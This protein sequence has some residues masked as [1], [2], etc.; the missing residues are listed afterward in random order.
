MI[1][2]RNLERVC[3]VSDTHLGFDRAKEA[4]FSKFLDQDMVKEA[5]ELILLGDIVDH[6]VADDRVLFRSF[7][8]SIRKID[9]LDCTKVYVIGNHDYVWHRYIG[10]YLPD[11]EVVEHYTC[12]VGDKMYL[13]VHGHQY[14]RLCKGFSMIDVAN[15]LS[16]I[17]D[18]Q[19][20]ITKKAVK[21]AFTRWIWDKWL[22][23]LTDRPKYLT[24]EEIIE[25]GY[26]N[27]LKLE[28]DET[29]DVL[30]S[31]H[32]HIP[33]LVD[34]EKG[35]RKF[36]WGNTGSWVDE[37]EL[38]HNTAI[39]IDESGPLL[40]QCEEDENGELKMWFMDWYEPKESKFTEYSKTE[41]FQN[42]LTKKKKRL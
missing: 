23:K 36:K 21:N 30:I 32:T 9:R 18:I 8:E 38:E 41:D 37:I 20:S 6:W 19:R 15:I 4:T 29:A 2:R 25:K 42:K 13:F 12:N 17:P 3:V 27:F 24:I 11:L 28:T 22:D 26:F 1:A 33:Q 14:D 10:D 40:C 5:D 7:Y 16:I 34:F 31:G 35:G 39:F